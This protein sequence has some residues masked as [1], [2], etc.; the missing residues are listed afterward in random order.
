MKTEIEKIL[1]EAG[2]WVYRLDL[3]P[4]NGEEKEALMKLESQPVEIVDQMIENI[5]TQK[6]KALQ[7]ARKPDWEFQIEKKKGHSSYYV[8]LKISQEPI[9]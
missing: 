5:V 7:E 6:A 4:E 9:Y 8:H 2:H 1:E 3:F